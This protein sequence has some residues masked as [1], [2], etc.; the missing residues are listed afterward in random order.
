MAL[1][2]AVR[3]LQKEFLDLSRHPPELC[4]AGPLEEDI[5]TWQAVVIGPQGSP[6]EGGVFFLDIVFPSTYPLKPP[7]VQFSTPIYHPNVNESG[8]IGLDLL[9]SKWAPTCTISQML[10][11]ICA[12]LADPSPDDILDPEIANMF[13]EDKPK[14]DLQA[15]KWTEEYAM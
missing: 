5:L 9:T 2:L 11:A 15:R 4:S 14:F 7:Q 10:L 6:Y 8:C 12:M 3:R 13:L 1:S